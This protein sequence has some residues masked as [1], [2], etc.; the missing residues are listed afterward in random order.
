MVAEGI[1]GV[2]PLIY[3]SSGRFDSWRAPLPRIEPRRLERNEGVVAVDIA[4]GDCALRTV[5]NS[6]RLV[7]RRDRARA[8]SAHD[9]GAIWRGEGVADCTFCQSA[10]RPQLTFAEP[11]GHVCAERPPDSFLARW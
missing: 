3:S 10:N 2:A 5:R 6:D 11:G 4:D 8:N 7:T 1:S 9:P